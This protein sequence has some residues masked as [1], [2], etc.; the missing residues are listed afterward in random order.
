MGVSFLSKFL[1]ERV[2]EA[3]GTMHYGMLRFHDLLQATGGRDKL[4]PELQFV[5]RRAEGKSQKLCKEKHRNLERC[6]EFCIYPLL[7]SLQINLT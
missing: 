1:N 3:G 4:A 6:A 5:R 7:V 2:C